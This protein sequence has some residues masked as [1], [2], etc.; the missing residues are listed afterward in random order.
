M[1]AGHHDPHVHPGRPRRGPLRRP[2]PEHQARRPQ[3]RD[4]D[5]HASCSASGR[6]SR[7]SAASSA[8]PA[9]TG[10]GRGRKGCS[11][12]YDARDLHRRRRGDHRRFW[13]VDMFAID[14]RAVVRSG[15]ARSNAPCR[16][17][18]ARVRTARKAAAMSR[19][20]F[21]RKSPADLAAACSARSSAG[22]THRVPVAEPE[23]R[24]RLG[25]QRRGVDRHQVAA[26]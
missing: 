13:C 14:L 2:Q 21:F 8:V 15:R 22:A 23:G 19:R 5:V 1:V 11:S 24:V 12:T 16:R 25:D 4:L 26:G 17:R 10:S 18:R 7:S 3:D 6:R 9:T 20:D